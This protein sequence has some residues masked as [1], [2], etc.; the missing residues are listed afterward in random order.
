MS[1]LSYL[2]YTL[3]LMPYH[4][5]ACMGYLSATKAKVMKLL[6]AGLI[7][8]WLWVRDPLLPGSK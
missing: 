7:A 5:A 6:Q 3:S 1:D 4:W 2:S 8:S